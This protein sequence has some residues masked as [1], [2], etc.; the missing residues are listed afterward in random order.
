MA[1]GYQ[2]TIIREINKK[3]TGTMFSR[4][5]PADA[6]FFELF[7]EAATIL[8]QGAVLLQDMMAKHE[9]MKG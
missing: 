6:K 2:D 1:L 7:E 5:K 4:F 9:T 3:E 8:H